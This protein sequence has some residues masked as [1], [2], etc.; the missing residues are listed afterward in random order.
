[1]AKNSKR[2]PAKGETG[3]SKETKQQFLE[4][5]PRVGMNVTAAARN[6]GLTSPNA[7]YR[8]RQHDKAFAQ[9][10]ADIEGEVLDALEADQF[11]AAKIRGEDRRWVLA[12]LRRNK[13]GDQKQ[14]QVTG[15]VEHRHV[16]ELTDKELA[17]I[18]GKEMIEADYEVKDE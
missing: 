9:A 5:L 18:A 1:M 13:W 2:S 6:S 10:W 16:R 17:E 4:W 15:E 11:E 12:R 3:V 8:Q 14:V 7:L